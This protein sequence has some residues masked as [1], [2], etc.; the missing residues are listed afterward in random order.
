VAEANIGKKK[1]KK[2]QKNRPNFIVNPSKS[3][4]LQF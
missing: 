3:I 4:N 1:V 2:D